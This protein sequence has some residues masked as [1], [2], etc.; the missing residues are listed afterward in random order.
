MIAMLARAI[1]AG[2]PFSW[3]TADE[4]YGQAGYL[5]DWLEEH[6]TG[7]VRAIRSIDLVASTDDDHIAAAEAIAALPS[8][9]WRRLSVGARAHGPREYDWAWIPIRMGWRPGR[10]HWLMARHSISDTHRDRLLRLLQAT[11][12]DVW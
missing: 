11:P 5:R 3:V 10:G 2:V 7:Y 9:A 4:V 12:L 1:D 8:R 6:D